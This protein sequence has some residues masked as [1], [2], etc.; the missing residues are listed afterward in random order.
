MIQP[1]ML[2][3]TP[4]MVRRFLVR[5]L[6]NTAALWA[7]DWL[8]A[9]FSVVGGTKGYLVA[10]LVLAVLHTFLRPLLKLLSLPLI[11]LSL[12][13]FTL[14]INVF[15]LWLAARWTGIIMIAGVSDYLWATFIISAANVLLHSSARE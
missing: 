1:E 8:L 10:G 11:I 14:V 4:V 15:I 7:A 12:G 6:V 3:W 5:F 2:G 9:G 13:F